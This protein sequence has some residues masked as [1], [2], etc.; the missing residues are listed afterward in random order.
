MRKTAASSCMACCIS[1]R[2]AAVEILPSAWRKRSKR[3]R[4]P[5]VIAAFNSGWVAPALMVSAAR[6]AAERPNTT[7]SIRL[8]EP[9]LLAPCTDT[10]AASPTAMRPGTTLSV[11]L[12]T[13]VTTSEKKFVCMPPML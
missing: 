11:S 2:S 7:R 1:S 12:P 4:W 3:A 10:Q 8:L 9:S 6:K 5:S 13:L